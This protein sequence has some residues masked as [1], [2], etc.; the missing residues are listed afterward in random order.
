DD[1]V[2]VF[3]NRRLAVDLGGLHVPLEKSVTISSATAANF[4][5]LV[6]GKFYEIKVFHAERK[7][8][9][10]SFK[11]TLAGFN[12][13]RSECEATCGD[14][15]IGGSEECDD[16]AANNT[17]GYNACQADCTL[18]GYCGDGIKQEGEQCDDRDPQTAGSCFGCAIMTVN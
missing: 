13:G 9:G 18:S 6:N 5:N 7:P 17:G 15:I 8:T 3:V 1:D 2:W 16:G 4:G 11:L 14:G 10:S 12:T